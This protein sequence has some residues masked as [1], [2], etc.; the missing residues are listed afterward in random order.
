[1]LADK[2]DGVRLS[3]LWQHPSDVFF[4]DERDK[5]IFKKHVPNADLAC[6]P[7]QTFVITHFDGLSDVTKPY[8]LFLLRSCKVAR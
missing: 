1:M 3:D 2:G 7:F 6:D 4:G 5:V 8:E